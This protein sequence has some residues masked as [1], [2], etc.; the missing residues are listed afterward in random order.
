VWLKNLS[1]KFTALGL[2][3]LLWFHVATDKVYEYPVALALA[4]GVLPRQ[5]ALA[6]PMPD[7]V[8]LL[9][10][11]TGKELLRF[12]W[13]D[14]QVEFLLEPRMTGTYPVTPDRLLLQVGADVDIQ[15]VL[16]PTALTVEVDTVVVRR[17]PVKY[18]GE[19]ALAL[20]QALAAPPRVSPDTIELRGPRSLLSKLSAVGTTSI[21]AGLLTGSMEQ[22][23]GLEL[24]GP[25]SVSA[26]PDSVTVR[27]SLER[28]MPRTFE[29]VPVRVPAG[30]RAEPPAVTITLAGAAE[31]LERVRL[32]DLFVSAALE[33]STGDPRWVDVEVRVPPLL[34]IRSVVPEQ[35]RLVAR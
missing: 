21:D 9:V 3:A 23:L 4:P 26:T 35:V 12:L 31:P 33:R 1:L 17:V 24:D 2:A 22:T 14:G 5:F 15:Q 7:Q 16:D 20:D 10:S 34:D 8:R 6:T 25:P 30:W 18:Q 27:F 28:A 32:A 19:Y 11:G 13:D 29:A